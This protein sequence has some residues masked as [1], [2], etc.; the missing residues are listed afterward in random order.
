MVEATLQEIPGRLGGRD[1]CEPPQVFGR[2]GVPPR[3]RGDFLHRCHPP[4][5]DLYVTGQ[6]VPACPA[7]GGC[8]DGP[9]PAAGSG[10]SPPWPV[11][12]PTRLR[13]GA[14]QPTDEGTEVG[15][16][17][18]AAKRVRVSRR[19]HRRIVRVAGL[20]GKGEAG[21]R[22]RGARQTRR[23]RTG[24]LAANA[25]L[26]TSG[27]P[28]THRQIQ[29]DRR[30]C[31]GRLP[32]W[33]RCQSGFSGNA[34][35]RYG[36]F[37]FTVRPAPAREASLRHR[38]IITTLNVYNKLLCHYKAYFFPYYTATLGTA[39][40]R[41]RRETSPRPLPLPNA[42]R[43]LARLP[44]HVAAVVPPDTRKSTLT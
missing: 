21:D 7:A 11:R 39:S 31:R 12:V 16:H 44:Q 23:T 43:L 28:A 3:R 2:G 14:R 17:R 5:V 24:E 13:E 42:E 8:D 18:P 27:S 32:L 41:R 4:V 19:C 1:A 34:C 15:F 40:C 20:A 37:A 26:T 9:S 25:G 6:A 22:C 10:P 33:S 29:A 30:S 38:C 36:P 35:P